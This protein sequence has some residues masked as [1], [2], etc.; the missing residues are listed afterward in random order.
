MASP[1]DIELNQLQWSA[2]SQDNRRFNLLCAIFVVVTI[3][4]GIVIPR[5]ELPEAA[6][7]TQTVIPKQLARVVLEKKIE[8]EQK[9][10]IPQPELELAP[11]EKPERDEADKNQSQSETARAQAEGAGLLQNLDAL[12]QLRDAFDLSSVDTSS[13]KQGSAQ[14][15]TV[16][17][18]L[19]VDAAKQTS[20]GFSAADLSQDVGGVALGAQEATE[21]YSGL[22]D[23]AAEKDAEEALG[24]TRSREQI[25]EVFQQNRG[26]FDNAYGRERR[27]YPELKGTFVVLLVIEP[28]GSVSHAEMLSSDLNNKGLEERLVVLVRMINFGPSTSI[29][30]TTQYSLNF[31]PRN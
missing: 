31:V 1:L 11:A 10:P 14:A 22:A 13:R 12:A 7:E 28:D 15:D 8:R 29:A 25:R 5:I 27:K 30:T 23:A 18:D 4:L 16:S 21:V 24:N 3:L 26:R 19:L 20:G 2:S 9:K 17:R 6:I